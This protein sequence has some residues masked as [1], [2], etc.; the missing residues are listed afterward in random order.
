MLCFR[1]SDVCV[2]TSD[3]AKSTKRYVCTGCGHVEA[4]WQGQCAGCGD[5]NTLQE[6]QSGN[7]SAAADR[8]SQ[9]GGGRL[10][11]LNG[12]DAEVKLPARLKTG[13]AELDSVLGGGIVEGSAILISGPPGIG[14]STLLIQAAASIARQGHVTAYISGEEAEDQVRL[15][16]QR[17]DLADAPVQLGH[18][19]SVRDILTTM[20]ER[21]AKVLIVDSI[22]TM[23]SDSTDGGPGGP[24]Q[25]KA[26]G[27]ALIQYAKSNGCAV[28]I[29]GHV[30]K[31]NE[32][33]GP[34]H[35][36]HM[37]D[38]VLSFDGDRSHQFRLLRAVKNRFGATDEVGVFEMGERGLK[39]VLNPSSLFL[40]DRDEQTSG[41]CVMPTVEGGRSLLIEIQALVVRRNSE[42]GNPRR[43]CVGWD[44]T[45][46]DMILAL[47]EARYG[48]PFGMADVY[49]NVAGG[50]R[51]TDPGADLA[52]ASACMSA[53][54]DK[55]L[56][57]GLV[58]FGELALSGDVRPV[59]Y[60]GLRL[61][62]AA[63]QGFETAWTPR[64]P[65]DVT[66]PGG[67]QARSIRAYHEIVNKVAGAAA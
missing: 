62:E 17:L 54:T 51:L 44:K 48:M 5:W 53:F 29:V 61:R 55:P 28:I 65:N 4:K 49:L 32:L 59:P 43:A 57:R 42:G 46:L 64:L 11:P 3:M 14:K 8:R 37:V 41:N 1:Q 47:L 20:A 58:A 45:R 23:I 31:D 67:L 60:M 39:E 56:P 18:E 34:K 15:R 27:S 36:E 33:A 24:G 30:N 9:Q 63:R 6:D 26:S 16:A 35:L 10:I 21:R 66:V 13:I 38:A 12:L 52:V 19:T 2:I 7:Q 22:Q 50:Y 25:I 40:V